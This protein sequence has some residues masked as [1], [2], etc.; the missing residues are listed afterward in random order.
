MPVPFGE[1]RPDI[2]LTDTQF[3]S[4]LENVF[5]GVNSYLPFPS[6]LAFSA[7]LATIAPEVPCGLYSARLTDG[8]WKIYV[9]TTTKLYSWALAGFTDIS[10]TTGG[11]YAVPPG[12][13]WVFE[14]SGDHVVAVQQGDVPQWLEIDSGS[15]HFE[16][17]PGSPPRAGQVKQIG[18]F[19]VLSALSDD[20]SN[21]TGTG[22]IAVNNRSV[23]WSG[24]MTS[25]CGTQE[26][27]C[28]TCK[29]FPTVVR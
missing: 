5:A 15:A 7:A 11:A 24:S 9:G 17:L 20:A 6:L 22:A 18:D 26:P 8:T 2:A 19:L 12:D 10:R 4:E 13:L 16:A 27:T 23:V 28:A 29:S 3:A 25:A 14:Q 1:W 21:T